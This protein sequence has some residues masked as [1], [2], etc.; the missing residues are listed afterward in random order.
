M[1]SLIKVLKFTFVI[2]KDRIDSNTSKDLS[3]KVIES[4][5]NGNVSS[6]CCLPNTVVNKISCNIH[7]SCIWMISACTTN[8]IFNNFPWRIT[9]TI[10]TPSSSSVSW[11]YGNTTVTTAVDVVIL[12]RRF[13]LRNTKLLTSKLVLD[14]WHIHQQDRLDHNEDH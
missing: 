2:S 8:C 7:N 14:S 6:M 10:V 5:H 12:K 1:S 9:I 4:V 3:Y 11:I 13:K